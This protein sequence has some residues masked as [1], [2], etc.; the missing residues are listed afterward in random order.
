[1]TTHTTSA[2]RTLRRAGQFE[3]V[4]EPGSSNYGVI[5]PRAYVE[6]AQFQECLAKIQNGESAIVNYGSQFSKSADT[7]SLILVA[8]QT[9]YAAWL[10]TRELVAGLKK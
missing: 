10:G 8:I 5:G 9:D 6:S 1:M 4:Q 3:I 2:V 7:L